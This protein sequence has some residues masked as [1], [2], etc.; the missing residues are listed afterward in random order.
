MLQGEHSAILLTFI[1]LQFFIKSFV[2]SIMEW[3]FYTGLTVPRFSSYPAI[4]R[5]VYENTI[6][7]QMP[8]K[9]QIKKTK[10][11]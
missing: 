2:L 11:R 7:I 4:R 1:K 5:R 10:I 9:K 6:E 3:T 8:V